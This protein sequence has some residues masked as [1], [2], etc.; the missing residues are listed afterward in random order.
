MFSQLDGEI[1]IRKNVREEYR[2]VLIKRFQELGGWSEYNR[3]RI[4]YEQSFKDNYS[5]G[6][7]FKSGASEFNCP[8][9]YDTYYYP[10]IATGTIPCI[11]DPDADW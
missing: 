11:N 6:P 3:L 10:F 4:M 5:R 1:T 2:T 8:E 7:L 9:F